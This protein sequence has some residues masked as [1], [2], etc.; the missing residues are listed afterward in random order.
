MSQ[1]SDLSTP[2]PARYIH[3]NPSGGG[4]YV[5][6]SIVNQRLLMAVG[7]YK[8]ELV[9]ILRGFVPA[10]KPKSTANSAR[11]K[12]G[13]PELPNVVVGVVMR[14]TCRVDD[15]ISVIEEAGDCEDP[16][17][18]P[19]DGAR[20][21]DATSDAFKRCCMRLGLGLHL[22]A[23]DDYFLERKL[24]ETKPPESPLSATELAGGHSIGGTFEGQETQNNGGYYP[25]DDNA[26]QVE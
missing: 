21:K 14:L 6:H 1:L 2:F 8:L 23:P 19:H 10:I 18:W 24:K 25:L 7:P 13:A 15:E 11:G 17:N 22:W 20:L 26:A 12:E 4:S 16:H 5:K 3:K 9:E